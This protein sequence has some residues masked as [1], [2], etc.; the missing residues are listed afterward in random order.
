MVGNYVLSAQFADTLAVR[1]DN[2]MR[3]VFGPMNRHVLGQYNGWHDNPK[4][5]RNVIYSSF[6]RAEERDRTIYTDNL[7]T[8]FIDK[9][10]AP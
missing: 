1:L 10:A 2:T 3:S 8:G 7:N 5:Y 9:N 6:K 4:T